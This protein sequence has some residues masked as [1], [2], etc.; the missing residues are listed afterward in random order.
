M[1]P[2]CY[3]DLPSSVGHLVSGKAIEPIVTGFR[4]IWEAVVSLSRDEEANHDDLSDR[5][6][7]LA[8]FFSLSPD[9]R[10]RVLF[11]LGSLH[12]RQTYFA[13]AV[14]TFCRCG[15]LIAEMLTAQGRD[16]AGLTAAS[17]TDV[18]LSAQAE[19]AFTGK[20]RSLFERTPG[21]RG[22]CD[23]GYMTEVILHVFIHRAVAACR[24]S[25]YAKIF[26]LGRRCLA[27]LRPLSESRGFVELL[28]S[29][30][31]EAGDMVAGIMK[32]A[33]R[34]LNS[35]WLVKYET[36]ECFIY[37]EDGFRKL[38]DDI[39][40]RLIRMASGR[41]IVATNQGHDLDRTQSNKDIFRVFVRKV[42][43]F[44]GKDEHNARLTNFER[45]FNVKQFFNDVQ[46]PNGVKR[47]IIKVQTPFPSI[48]SRISVKESDITYVNLTDIEVA[49]IDLEN[50]I[51]TMTDLIRRKDIA[52]LRG[53][54]KGAIITEV[55][56]GLM[57]TVE[58]YLDGSRKEDAHIMEMAVMIRQLFDL[59]KRGVTIC[60]EY[61]NSTPKSDDL[62]RYLT[63]GLEILKSKCQPYLM[64]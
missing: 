50:M 38:D 53:R 44:F 63:R 59:L 34:E 55:N 23:S 10:V 21:V 26:E 2:W 49:C 40:F 56:G 62:L 19:S 61:P 48:T 37:H 15:A 29:E 3:S 45:G 7:E 33:S 13:E 22:I 31:R 35:F 42:E 47:A 39:S 52:G 20:I 46:G 18:C 51:L 17:F 64:G 5:L 43:P 25:R 8:D 16:I 60:R 32:S 54:M 9:I 24:E 58:R 41:K 27:V 1:M 36:G 14:V 12:V 57:N 4:R 11:E 6:V 30:E 28:S